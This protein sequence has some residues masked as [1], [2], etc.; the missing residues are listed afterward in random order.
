V[1]SNAQTVS[2]ANRRA[3][4]RATC[5]DAQIVMDANRQAAQRAAQSNAQIA[6]E[7]VARANTWTFLH[8]NRQQEM[9]NADCQAH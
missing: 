7:N 6:L 3:A 2:D 4:K 8:F 5:S 1:G 9:R